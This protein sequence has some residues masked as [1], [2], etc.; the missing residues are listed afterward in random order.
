MIGGINRT[1]GR[2]TMWEQLPNPN[3]DSD[4]GEDKK[5]T[6]PSLDFQD[7]FSDSSDSSG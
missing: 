4:G 7:S 6:R 3:I 5:L 2:R 1:N